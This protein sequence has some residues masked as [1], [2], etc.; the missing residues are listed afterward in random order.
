MMLVRIIH[1]HRQWVCSQFLHGD[2]RISHLFDV[3]PVAFFDPGAQDFADFRLMR[4]KNS[5]AS[6]AIIDRIDLGMS[7]LPDTTSKPIFG[8]SS[9]SPMAAVVVVDD[10][11]LSIGRLFAELFHLAGRHEAVTRLPGGT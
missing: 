3:L 5:S 2:K 7:Y 10:P 9:R 1:N 11:S 4:P 8:S 6:G